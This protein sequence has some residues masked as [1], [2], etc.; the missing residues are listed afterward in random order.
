MK[1]LENAKDLEGDYKL[2]VATVKECLE[3]E[4]SLQANLANITAIIN[5]YLN[6]INWVGFYINVDNVL[7]LNTFQGKIAC[8]RIP[9]EKGVCGKCA[10]IGETVVVENV[11]NFPEHIACDSASV[12]EIAA[13]IFIGDIIFGVLDI[14]SPKEARFTDLEKK[15]IDEISELISKF[16]DNK[17]SNEV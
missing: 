4:E 2:M 6:D 5:H 15:Y 14:D 13:P 16:V 12:S 17:F 11:H 10:S 3:T 7:V 9:F 1:I 8:T